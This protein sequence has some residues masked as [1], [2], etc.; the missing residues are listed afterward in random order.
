MAVLAAASGITGSLAG[1][2]R[3]PSR[4]QRSPL[5]ATRPRSTTTVARAFGK[6]G[7]DKEVRKRYSGTRRSTFPLLL[8]GGCRL[9]CATG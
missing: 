6:G 7:G 5:L 3:L 9:R 8:G 2:A 1:H 4:P